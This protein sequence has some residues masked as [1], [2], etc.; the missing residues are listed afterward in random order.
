MVRNRLKPAFGHHRLKAVRSGHITKMLEDLRLEANLRDPTK[1]LSE[2]SIQHIY[3]GL[4]NAL[5]WAVR[6]R[7]IARNPMEG[8]ER[9]VREAIEM[10]IWTADELSQFLADFEDERLFPIY[11]VAAFTEMRRFE[12]RAA[13]ASLASVRRCE[14]LGLAEAFPWAGWRDA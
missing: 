10:K 6:Q 11:R 2:T 7:M 13:Q 14:S 5:E 4:N 1:P 12:L 8:V 9:P 3:S